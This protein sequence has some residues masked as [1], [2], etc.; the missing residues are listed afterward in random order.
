M[1]TS[2]KPYAI[3]LIKWLLTL[4]SNSSLSLSASCR[5]FHAILFY[6]ILNVTFCRCRVRSINL[7]LR[8]TSFF[9]INFYSSSYYS[10]SYCVLL[11]PPFEWVYWFD[12]LVSVFVSA[13]CIYWK[14]WSTYVNFFLH[15]IF[16][17]FLFFTCS[18]DHSNS[19][20]GIFWNTCLVHAIC[21]NDSSLL[22]NS[23]MCWHAL[24]GGYWDEIIFSSEKTHSIVLQ[25]FS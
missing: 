23:Y 4:L 8:V 13:L 20:I 12:L 6:F 17:L 18:S 25:H 16:P 10:S 11:F 14:S 3:S 15:I 21:D 2:L 19:S 9:I 5:F 7:H 24:N 22:A 1:L